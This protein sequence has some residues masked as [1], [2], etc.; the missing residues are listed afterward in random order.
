MSLAWQTTIED[1]ETV[2]RA[3]KQPSQRSEEYLK[4]L[5]VF[6]VEEAALYG[7]TLEEQTNYAYQNIETQLQQLGVLPT[8]PTQFPV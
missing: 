6:K 4:Q 2:L 7:N 3:H 1:V 8:G 5:D